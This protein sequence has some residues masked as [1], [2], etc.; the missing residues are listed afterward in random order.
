MKEQKEIANMLQNMRENI[1]PENE[2]TNFVVF[3]PVTFGIIALVAIIFF[4]FLS[5]YNEYQEDKEN[6]EI[7]QRIWEM[8]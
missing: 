4:K 3:I 1:V 7:L 8:S 5:S 6:V 2:R